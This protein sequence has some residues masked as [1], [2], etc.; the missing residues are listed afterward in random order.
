MVTREEARNLF[1]EWVKTESLKKHCLSVA[2]SVE[3]YAK[4]LGEDADMWWICGLMHDFDYER[5]PTMEEHPY[6]GVKVL[7]EKSYPE[8][9]IEAIMGHGNHTGVKR[10][11]KMAKVLFAVDEL[12]GFVMAV[13]R[14]RPSNFEGMTPKS[15]KKKLKEKSFAAAINRDDINQGIEELGVDKDEHFELVIQALS[16]TKEDLGF[17]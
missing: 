5:Y 3:A 10:E 6:E 15:V 7:K 13:A 14:V 16:G 8:E 2:A 11:S 17:S 4:K 9:I 1:D 12:S